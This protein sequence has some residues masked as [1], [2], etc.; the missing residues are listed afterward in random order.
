ML[1]GEKSTWPLNS[2]GLRVFSALAQAPSHGL[3]SSTGTETRTGGP[4]VTCA[5]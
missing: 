3:T 5:G 1:F 4:I 2:I